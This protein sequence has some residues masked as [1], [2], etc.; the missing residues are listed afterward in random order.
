LIIEAF[1][2]AIFV[3]FLRRGRLANL[4]RI[5]LRHYF[6]F[7]APFIMFAAVCTIAATDTSGR[8]MPYVRIANVGQYILLLVAIGLNVH[9]RELWFAG[10]GT[11]LNFLVLT[12]N[13]GMMPVSRMGLKLAGLTWMLTSKETPRFVR[14]A[15]MDTHTRLWMLG[16]IIPIPGLGARNFLAEVASIGDVLVAAAVFVLVQQYMVRTGQ[17]TEDGGTVDG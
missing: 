1:L 2:L 7:V 13:G 8:M 15:I 11:F 10:L 5:P 4:G 9:L 12:V 17:R 14:H 3:G 6:L 16:D